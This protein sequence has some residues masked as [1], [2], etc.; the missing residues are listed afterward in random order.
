MKNITKKFMSLTLSFAILFG[1]LGV[2]A[3][4]EASPSHDRYMGSGDPPPPPHDRH[5]KHDRQHNDNDDN[6]THSEGDVIT[7]G[8]IGVVVGAIIAKN[9]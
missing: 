6:N 7:S 1:S 9:T 3:T 4:T 5:H 8:I 2:A